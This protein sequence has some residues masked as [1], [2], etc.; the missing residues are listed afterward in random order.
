MILETSTHYGQPSMLPL[1]FAPQSGF[2]I[3]F[4]QYGQLPGQAIGGWHPQLWNQLGGQI[5]NPLYQHGQLGTPLQQH[6]PFGTPLQQQ[7]G[8]FSTP[9][10]QHGPFGTQFQQQYGPFSTPLQ[11]QYG[12]FSTPLQQQYGPFG[13]PWQQQYGP[14]GTP[15]QQYGQIGHPLFQY[16]QLAGQGL[17]GW[18]GHPQFGQ[19]GPL[20]QFGQLGSPL[21]QYAQLLGQAIGGWHGQP[22]L[23][24][25]LAFPS[26]MALPAFAPQGL[27]GTP[28]ASPVGG[29]PSGAFGQRGWASSLLPF[30]AA[31]Q[32]AY[33][34]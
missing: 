11:Q 34:G 25:Q 7:Y 9:L 4:G 3:P 15:P 20:Q 12:P 33:A 21:Q 29:F 16:G 13:T 26:V 5:G 31:P 22:Q 24:G 1:Q 2:G 17:G 6:G 27:F 10:Q 23:C 14:F 28:I 30:Q 8:P 19:I 32:M 18:F